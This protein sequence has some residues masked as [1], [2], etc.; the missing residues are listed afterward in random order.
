MTWTRQGTAWLLALAMTGCSMP[1]PY[2]TYSPG[3]VAAPAL[4]Q[5][6]LTVYG[7]TSTR[8]QGGLGLDA[9]E[10]PSAPLPAP[11]PPAA[12]TDNTG[13]AICYNRLW[14]SPATVKSAAAAACGSGK[15]PR[16]MSQGFEL[17][18][19]PVMTPMR[20][21]FACTAAP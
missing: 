13:I 14:N 2:Q 10:Q 11:A 21:V 1:A 3:Q 20:A 9:V 17:D 5:N 8:Q 19:C 15:V 12:A 18:A 7:A 6:A 16:V 4:P